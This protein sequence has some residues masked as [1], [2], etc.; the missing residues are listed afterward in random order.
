MRQSDRLAA[1][2]QALALAFEGRWTHAEMA[3]RVQVP[4]RTIRR[5][6]AEPAFRTQLQA[7]RANLAESLSD[8]AYADKLSR[9]K[10]LSQ[11]AESARR[12]Y[13]A[14]P[15]LKEI[16]PTPDGEIVN[17]SFNR[18]AHAAFRDSLND[19]AKELGERVN[20]QDAAN[21]AQVL[22]VAI[23]RELVEAV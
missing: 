1:K 16:R 20:K 10:A 21:A 23:G 17:E 6:L 22:I 2:K 11:M 8:V 15:W 19:I 4:A 5:W 12:E 3:A 7:A 14:R 18:D 9:I 13:E